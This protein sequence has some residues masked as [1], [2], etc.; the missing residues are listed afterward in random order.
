[1]AFQQ[2]TFLQDFLDL[3]CPTPQLRRLL[4]PCFEP[5]DMTGKSSIGEDQLHAQ[6]IQTKINLHSLQES[7]SHIKMIIYVF[8]SK[9][10]QSKECHTP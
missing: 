1:M 6:R 3:T 2:Y 5:V 10:L 9:M 4:E 7:N 8:S